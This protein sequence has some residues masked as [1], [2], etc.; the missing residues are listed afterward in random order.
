MATYYGTLLNTMYF[1]SVIM[2]DLSPEDVQIINQRYT[3][4][5]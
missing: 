1:K 5:Y 4:I 2:K 3:I